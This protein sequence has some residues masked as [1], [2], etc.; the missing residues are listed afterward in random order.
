M[1]LMEQ[2]VI[3]SELIIIII[4]RVNDMIEI[5]EKPFEEIGEDRWKWAYDHVEKMINQMK[6]TYIY[7]WEQDER[8]MT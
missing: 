2:H 6:T 7:T 5:T 1:T 4:I 3:K 8:F